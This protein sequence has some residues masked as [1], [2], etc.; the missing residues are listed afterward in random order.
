MTESMTAA[1]LGRYEDYPALWLENGRA[2]R[3]WR[4]GDWARGRALY[5]HVY[6]SR[7]A[8]GFRR[9]RNKVFTEQLKE[10]DA[11]LHLG[12]DDTITGLSRVSRAPYRFAD[13]PSWL[14]SD[15][16][17]P[18]YRADLVGYRSFARAVPLVAVKTHPAVLDE[19]AHQWDP[20]YYPTY[21]FFRFDRSRAT[22]HLVP[23]RYLGRVT[24]AFFSAV[25]EYLA[26][27]DARAGNNQ[28]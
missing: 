1:A 15:A 14:G 20:V 23:D 25:Y 21:H 4:V 19:L 26:N 3:E 27:A 11:V 2:H 7:N 13:P 24:P 10:G 28:F 22:A 6:T 18:L 17:N 12:P 5:S 16:D 9:Q 8:Q